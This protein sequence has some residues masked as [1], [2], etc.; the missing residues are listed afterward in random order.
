M[1]IRLSRRLMII[2][3]AVCLVLGAGTIVALRILNS[4]QD[5][6]QTE[7]DPVSTKVSPDD[8]I[9]LEVPGVAKI[10][11]SAGSVA[12][13]GALT[14]Y[15][16]KGSM[17]IDTGVRIAGA[18][19]D[20]AILGTTLVKPLTV[21][22]LSAETS[23]AK[24][25]SIAVLHR[26][27]N[28]SMDVKPAT[29]DK[30]GH[31]VVETMYFS[32]N[33][34]IHL[35]LGRWF[36]DRFDSLADLVAGRTDPDPCKNDAPAWLSTTSSPDLVHACSISN[37][38]GSGVTRAE[39]Q[40]KSNRRSFVFAR[41]PQ[42]AAYI[43]VE[44]QPDWLR[45]A[46]AK[47][48]GE[49]RDTYLL[50]PGNTKF[51]AGFYQP[52]TTQSLEFKFG[53]DGMSKMISLISPLISALAG[54]LDQKSTLGAAALLANECA[55]E[56]P[57]SLAS[58]DGVLEVLR[59]VTGDGLSKLDNPDKA[60][61]AAM[62]LFGD[63]G[64]SRS[65]ESALSRTT[66]SL[67]LLGKAIGFFGIGTLVRDVV[68]QWL[69][70]VTEML[71][72]KAFNS[73]IQLLGK[74]GGTPGGAQGGVG[75]GGGS[76]SDGLSDPPTGGDV[77]GGGPA[78]GNTWTEQSGSNGSPTFQNVSNASGQG[79]TIPPMTNVQVSCKV[80]PSSTIGSASPDG[81]WYRIASPPWNNNY[82]AVAN[83]FWNGDVPGQKPYTH[84][85]DFAVADC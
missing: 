71:V 46:F 68:N 79:Q 32:F 58:A 10:R 62:N 42:G 55:D 20:V 47:L 11:G 45:T 44:D 17:P 3:L 63:A 70:E 2:A 51:T 72:P 39:V 43:W 4:G 30:A 31:V 25:T 36:R 34:P 8:P 60:F 29:V 27:K 66:G 48:A 61:S 67:Q 54:G 85:T 7:G 50:I 24:G 14:A 5:G 80:K 53:V 15:A 65:A 21:T 38:N 13:D 23:A 81:Y 56:V 33:F 57:T 84:N 49:P 76:S 40:F 78:P 26:S 82:F 12:S 19:V 83:T 9:A 37:P 28:G 73:S 74:A 6:F 59:C 64:Y 16:A 41:A 52:D 69:T 1:T 35:D 22:F 75:G 18:G 77:T